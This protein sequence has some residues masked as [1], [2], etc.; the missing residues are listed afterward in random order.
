MPQV[1]RTRS[2]SSAVLSLRLKTSWEELCRR[3]RWIGWKFQL[4]MRKSFFPLRAAEP[5]NRQPRDIMEPPSVETFQT[6]LDMTPCH[7]TLPWQEVGLMM[8]RGP[9]QPCQLRDPTVG[10]AVPRLPTLP[11]QHPDVQHS[12]SPQR[13]HVSSTWTIR[14]NIIHVHE[15]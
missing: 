9:F 6:Q 10:T 7:L 2:F 3:H 14:F 15:Q 13:A 11:E 5:W 4:N 8:S 12:S 1:L